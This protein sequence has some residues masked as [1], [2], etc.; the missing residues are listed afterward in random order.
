MK[1]QKN[2]IVK[3][4]KYI[5]GDTVK[6]KHAGRTRTGVVIEL[7]KKDT[8]EATYTVESQRIIYPQ[9]GIDGSNWIGYIITE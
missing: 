4:H 3:R 1:K 2:T 7:T 6:F 8:G 9:L 5:V